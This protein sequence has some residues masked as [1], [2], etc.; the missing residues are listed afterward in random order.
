MILRLKEKWILSIVSKYFLVY[1]AGETFSGKMVNR[2]FL[3]K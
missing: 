3:G 1:L 2:L